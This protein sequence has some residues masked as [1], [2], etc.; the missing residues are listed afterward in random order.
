V[1]ARHLAKG[2]ADVAFLVKPVHAAA[3]RAGF[4]VHQHRCGGV[5]SETV[6]ARVVTSAAEAGAETWDA[7]L[8][9]VPSTALASTAWL[10]ELALATGD[11][12]IVCFGP[13]L[14][15]AARVAATVGEA[16]T[17][18]GGI[19]LMAWASPLAGEDAPPGT[20]YWLPPLAACPFSSLGGDR[21]RAKAIARAFRA[22][23]L[24]ASVHK[25]AV[26]VSMTGAAVL[27]TT[28]A[29]LRLSGWSRRA[30]RRDRAL[31][32]VA[33]EAAREAIAIASV[34][35]GVPAPAMARAIGPRTIGA[36]LGG[37]ARLAPMDVDRFFEAH[38]SKLAAQ[39]KA[40]LA[41]WAARARE[42]GMP[43]GAIDA[44]RERVAEAM[45]AA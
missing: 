32:R 34:V 41:T 27:E 6:R 43:H 35:R 24:R 7:V 42:H 5:R 8:L 16:R 12:T 26:G 21:A 1:F 23:G 45:H 30:L 22:G 14:G 20:A 4:A 38:Y 17:V 29:A 19:A 37:L 3:A 39:S 13:G 25:D 11:A 15:D 33:A 44:L 2:G 31:R 18:A 10:G 28:A 36:V 9:C 40:G